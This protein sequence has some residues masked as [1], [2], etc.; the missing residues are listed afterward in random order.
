MTLKRVVFEI[1]SPA[2]E[3]MQEMAPVVKY[4]ERAMIAMDRVREDFQMKSLLID[5]D[6]LNKIAKEIEGCY[7]EVVAPC[8]IEFKV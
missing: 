3:R 1:L 2:T 7:N 6:G 5:F 4:L 8:V